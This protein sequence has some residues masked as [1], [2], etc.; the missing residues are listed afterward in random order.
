MSPLAYL[1]NRWQSN[2]L[3]LVA[4]PGKFRGAS[5]LPGKL[6]VETGMVMRKR[7]G[8]GRHLVEFLLCSVRT[9]YLGST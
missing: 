9:F 7:H 1:T 6:A 3:G 5:F 4:W 8:E 2:F